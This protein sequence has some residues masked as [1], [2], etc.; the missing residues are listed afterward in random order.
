MEVGYGRAISQS[1]LVFSFRK[2]IYGAV[3]LSGAPGKHGSRQ[4][5]WFSLGYS[6]TDGTLALVVDHDIAP[7]S[8]YCWCSAWN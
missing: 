3:P 4:L 1:S 8:V 2:L 7:A 6:H 5:E